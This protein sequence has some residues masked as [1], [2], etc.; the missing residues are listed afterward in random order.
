MCSS[1]MGARGLRGIAREHWTVWP[2]RGKGAGA[3]LWGTPNAVQIYI[4]ELK[5]QTRK[6]RTPHEL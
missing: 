3:G 1:R 2:V 4:S 6:L 5:Q